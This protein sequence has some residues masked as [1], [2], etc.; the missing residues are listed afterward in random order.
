MDDIVKLMIIL[1]KFEKF[2]N[3]TNKYAIELTEYKE[4]YR[5]YLIDINEPQENNHYISCIWSSPKVQSGPDTCKCCYLKFYP[6]R[7][8]NEIANLIGVDYILYT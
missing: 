8:C 4:K 1:K 6:H 5:Q 7:W 2:S 3:D